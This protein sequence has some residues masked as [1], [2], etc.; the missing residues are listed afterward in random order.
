MEII[1]SQNENFIPRCPE[2]FAIPIIKLSSN[3]NECLVEYECENEHKNSL[4]CYKYMNECH[5]FKNLKCM[6]CQKNKIENNN[7]EFLYCFKCKI[8]IC[9]ICLNSHKNKNKDCE[10]FISYNK[11][12][13]I[14]KIHDNS[15]DYYCNKCKKNICSFCYE[16]HKNHKDQLDYL[17]DLNN[18]N[19]IKEEIFQ[20]IDNIKNIK[21]IF[22][23]IQKDINELL[24]KIIFI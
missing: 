15:Y 9:N 6:E 20:S 19:I 3:N 5:Y 8:F 24:N 10:T 18:I 2:C 21:N 11:F 16:Q 22:E 4:P 17:K 13:G 7:I 1:K 14:C 12:D 23:N